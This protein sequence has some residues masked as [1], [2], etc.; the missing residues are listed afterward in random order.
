[1]RNPIFIS[2]VLLTLFL[3]S[4]CKMEK[5]LYRPGYHVEWT[6]SNKTDKK[7]VENPD[8]A[9]EYT[10]VETAEILPDQPAPTPQKPATERA[11]TPESDQ[12]TVKIRK[13]PEMIASTQ[14]LGEE[15]APRPTSNNFARVKNEGEWMQ[16]QT[17][18]SEH[19]RKTMESLGIA[20]FIIGVVG[21][22]VP[23]LG[24]AFVMMILA[25]I[26]GAVSLGKINREPNKYMGRGFGIT[27]LILGIIGL[28]IL[29]LLLSSNTE[30]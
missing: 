24:L 27:S 21:W 2:A 5:R 29:L 4:S 20:G 11:S 22:F 17:V 26:F 13:D 9:E 6:K 23:I 12:T 16:A 30:D 19:T 3:A 15:L 28:L 25:V 18:G 8:Q 14:D 7:S 10:S 1:M